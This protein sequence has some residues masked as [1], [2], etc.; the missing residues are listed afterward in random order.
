MNLGMG[1]V[2]DMNYVIGRVHSLGFMAASVYTLKSLSIFLLD[3]LL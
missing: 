1:F 2:G 3:G